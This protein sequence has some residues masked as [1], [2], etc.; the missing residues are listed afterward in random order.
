[1]DFYNLPFMIGAHWFI[2]YDFD[3]EKRKANRGLFTVKDEPYL[4]VIDALARAHERIGPA[5]LSDPYS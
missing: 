3:S 2:W 4:E 1:M 5:V